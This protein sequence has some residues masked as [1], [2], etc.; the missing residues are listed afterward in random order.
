[1]KK[2]CDDRR[3]PMPRVAVCVLACLAAGCQTRGQTGALAGAGLGAVIGQAAGGSTEATL[4][5][6]AVGTGVGYIIA[7]EMDKKAAKEEAE[8]RQYAHYTPPPTPLTGTHWQVI[9]VNPKPDP[10]FRTLVVQFQANGQV[11]VHKTLE[12]GVVLVETE[13]Y[14]VVGNTLIINKP[15]YVIN[16]R[17]RIDGTQLILDTDRFSGVL[18]R[19]G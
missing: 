5:G 9:S 15:G 8:N 11:V 7:N 10:P 18:Q 13:T 14:R 3:W 17:Y 6:A 4:I 12:N 16:A 2:S 1:M 19:V